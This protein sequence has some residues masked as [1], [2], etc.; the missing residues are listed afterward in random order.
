MAKMQLVL[1]DDAST[2]TEQ[3]ALEPGTASMVQD[4]CC[5]RTLCSKSLY[6]PTGLTLVGRV[7]EPGD[8]QERAE[9]RYAQ[10]GPHH[11]M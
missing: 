7:L 2:P 11:S 3:F 8:D 5:T 1:L 10:W 9:D 6:I 4:Y